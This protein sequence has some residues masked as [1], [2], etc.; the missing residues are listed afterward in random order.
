[1]AAVKPQT[2]TYAGSDQTFHFTIRLG[3]EASSDEATV[4]I[5]RVRYNI[6]HIS[7]KNHAD[8]II[9]KE[10]KVNKSL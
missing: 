9:E 6:L 3:D 1:M 4:D 7:A 10:F 8:V 5:R 2:V